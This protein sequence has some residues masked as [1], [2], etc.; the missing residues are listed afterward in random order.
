M[1]KNAI[2]Y[3]NDNEAQ[4]TKAFAKKAVIFGTEE[5]QLWK[6]YRMDFPD[7]KMA[8]KSIKKNGDK[9]TYKNLTYA[10]MK[11]FF[12]QQP[13]GLELLAEFEKQKALSKIQENPYRAVLAWFL[14]K[15]PN[16]DEYKEFFADGTESADILSYV[17]ERKAG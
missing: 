16:Y 10:N 1:I 5:Y 14:K 2:R 8:T 12:K 17:P 3:I 7:A 15:F 4:V 13:N 11:Q 6:S 9:K